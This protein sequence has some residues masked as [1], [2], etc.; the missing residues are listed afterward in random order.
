MKTKLTKTKHT[1]TET[2]LT[3]K[4]K[5]KHSSEDSSLKTVLGLVRLLQD[6]PYSS[7]KYSLPTVI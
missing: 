1:W 7:E 4:N 3:E 6:A 5:T 2:T